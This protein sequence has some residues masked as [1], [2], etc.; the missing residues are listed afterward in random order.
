[1]Q[2]LYICTFGWIMDPRHRDLTPEHWTS[3]NLKLQQQRPRSDPWKLKLRK[4]SQITLTQC[5]PAQAPPSLSPSLMIDYEN[6][7]VRCLRS[8][9]SF[10]SLLLWTSPF[11]RSD[12]VYNECPMNGEGRP[13]HHHYCFNL[14]RQ[15]S[16]STFAVE[17]LPD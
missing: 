14:S 13:Y 4:I 17:K 1:M 8:L 16:L 11:Q 3:F 12:H 6:Y 15:S 2:W 9:T 5:N 7:K 10:Q